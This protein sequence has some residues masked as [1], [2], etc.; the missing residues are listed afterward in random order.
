MKKYRSPQIPENAKIVI[1][2]G[3]SFTEGVG[4]WSKHTYNMNGGFI[5]PLKIPE[6]LYGEMYENSWVSQLCRNHLTDHIP[7][8]LGIMGKGNRAAVKEL[9]LNPEINFK[10]VKS[11]YLVMMLSGI[12]RFDFIEKDFVDH[13]F[14][15]MW[16]NPWDEKSTNKKLWECYAKDIW[17]EKFVLVEALLNIKEAE[18]F[19]HRHNLKFIVTSAFDQR[20]NKKNYIDQLGSEHKNLIDTIP[21]NNFLYPENCKSFMEFLLTLDGRPELANGGFYDY[22]SKLKSPTEYITNCMHPTEE[23]YRIIAEKIHEFIKGTV[24]NG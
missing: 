7:I 8:N 4:S 11:G 22:Y 13:H 10:N 15:T 3:D 1:G 18:Y 12:E 20:M 5:D 21:W 17:S 19:A 23:G 14:Y 2:I 16:P 6:N 9:Y 24:D